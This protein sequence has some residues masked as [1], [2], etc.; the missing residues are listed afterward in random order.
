[1]WHQNQSDAEAIKALKD[2][3]TEAHNETDSVAYARDEAY[4]M[5]ASY[6][7]VM[8]QALTAFEKMPFQNSEMVSNA[9]SALREALG[10]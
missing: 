5:L 7:A 10:Q 4:R 6:R 9:A 1:M 2:E 3:L 8:Q